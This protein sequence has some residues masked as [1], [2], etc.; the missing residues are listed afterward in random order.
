MTSPKPLKPLGSIHAPRQLTAVIQEA[1]IQGVSTRSVDDLV[2]AMGMDGISKSQVSRLCGEIDERVNSFLDRPIEGD[3]PY[4]WLDATYVKVRR[5]HHIVS[6]AVIVAVGVNTDGRHEVLGMTVGHSEAEPF[7]TEFLRTLTRRGLRGVKLVVS[8]AH[9]GLKAAITKTLGATWQRCRVHTIRTQ[10]RIGAGRAVAAGLR[11]RAEWDDMAYLQ[12]AVADDDALDDELQNRLLVGERRRLQPV[13]DAVAERFQAGA[14]RLG[15]DALLAQVV[16]VLLLALKPTPLFSEVPAPVCQLG[17]ADCAGLVGIEQ[18]LV[19]PRE[20]VQAGLE[21]L[22]GG[23]LADA[24]RLGSGDEVVKLR[25]QPVGAGEQAGDVVPHG[26]LDLLGLDA[27][28]RARCGP[29]SLDAVFAGAAVVAAPRL[30]GGRAV[31]APG[32]GQAA[33]RAGEQAAQEVAVP[34]VVPERERGVAGE[35]CLR[36]VPG[37]LVNQCRHGDSDPLIARFGLAA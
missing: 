19:G 28:V 26:V 17:Q 34:R 16:P 20:A 14:D 22:V 2:K 25:G 7:W 18:P 36:P 31:A 15:L 10:L 8:D 35:L 4:V 13:L 1:Y 9:E 6:V 3:W 29:S 27:A 23:T 37:V 11:R 24:A 5:D 21:L 32:H 12:A 30:A 33:A